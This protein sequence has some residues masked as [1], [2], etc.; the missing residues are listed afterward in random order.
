[1]EQNAIH[2]GLEADVAA[3]LMDTGGKK[4]RVTELLDTGVVVS[5]MPIKTLGENGL[6]QG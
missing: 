6:H 3:H 1:M 4:I 5:V 2:S